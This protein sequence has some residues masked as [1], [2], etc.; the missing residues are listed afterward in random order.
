MKIIKEA[1]ANTVTISLFATFFGSCA[2][3]VIAFIKQISPVY[4]ASLTFTALIAACL[5]ITYLGVVLSNKEREIKNL[6]TRLNR[7]IK[8]ENK[9]YIWLAD[10]TKNETS[11]TGAYSASKAL[12]VA[13]YFYNEG[14]K[15]KKGINRISK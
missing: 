7:T 10:L 12:H 9:F 4:L 8:S 2:V 15:S 6:E 14:V 5:F 11:R 3:V 13:A 1:M